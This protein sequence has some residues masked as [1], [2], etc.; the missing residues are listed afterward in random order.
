MDIFPLICVLVVIAVVILTTM[1]AFACHRLRHNPLCRRRNYI[2]EY[3]LQQPEELCRQY[4]L[5]ATAIS[6]ISSDGTRLW[7]LYAPP[8]NGAVIILLHGYKMDCGEM[9][10]IAAMLAQ[11]G[12][13]VLLADGRAHGRSDGE[14]I[15]FGLH[16]HQDIKAMVDFIT[17]QQ[18]VTAIGIFGNS[19]GGALGLCYAATDKR[20]AA[21]VA[22]SP[23]ASLGHSINKAL[24]QFCGLP[25]FPFATVMRLLCRI[26]LPINSPQLSPLAAIAAISPRAV[27]L[28]MGGNDDC[29]EAGG[30]FALHAN[31]GEP[32]QLWYE[33]HLGHVEFYQHRAEQFSTTVL[34]FYADNLL[35]NTPL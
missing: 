16:E 3:P 4:Q 11:H 9:V 23:Y 8:R 6:L 25:P 31:A 26:H 7:L 17:L 1:A 5:N 24:P 30:I 19:M 27:L 2:A 15:S 35:E 12:Y 18:G 28:L 22:H 32:K 33:P 29:V 21:T 13:G 10:P 14:Q 20:V 34:Q